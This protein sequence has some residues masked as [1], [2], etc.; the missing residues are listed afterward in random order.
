MLSREALVSLCYSW[1]NLTET[2]AIVRE[3]DQEEYWSAEQLLFA[4]RSATSSFNFFS[5][6]LRI[7]ERQGKPRLNVNS[8]FRREYNEAVKYMPSSLEAL[9]R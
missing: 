2:V 1:G 4:V 7:C 9:E 5:Y 8:V 3:T 6:E